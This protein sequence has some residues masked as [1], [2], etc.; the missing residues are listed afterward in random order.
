V[1]DLGDA[2]SEA[3]FYNYELGMHRD[4]RDRTYLEETTTKDW[5]EFYSK[6]VKMLI[7]SKKKKIFLDK[8]VFSHSHIVY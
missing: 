7:A 1:N 8:F 4:M 2:Q 3:T 6:K 5:R